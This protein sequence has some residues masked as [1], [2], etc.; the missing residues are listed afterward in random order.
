M[1]QDNTKSLVV[2]SSIHSIDLTD[3]RRRNSALIHSYEYLVKS[4]KRKPKLVDLT[5]IANQLIDELNARLFLLICFT[6]PKTSFK[7]FQHRVNF[8]LNAMDK[9]LDKILP[10]LHPDANFGTSQFGFWLFREE[11]YYYKAGERDE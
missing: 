2:L 7:S 4:L 11:F 1:K 6:F 5:A 8:V 9:C 10:D 3:F